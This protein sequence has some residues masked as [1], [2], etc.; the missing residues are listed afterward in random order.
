MGNAAPSLLDST[1]RVT[2]RQSDSDAM[3]SVAATAS[4][5]RIDAMA[6]LLKPAGLTDRVM[7]EHI[8]VQAGESLRATGFVTIFTGKIAAEAFVKAAEMR[9][10]GRYARDPRSSSPL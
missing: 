4:L 10:R 8:P 9:R 5:S 6:G 7:V 3:A 1:A 2:S